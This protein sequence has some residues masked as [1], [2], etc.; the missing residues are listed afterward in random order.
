MATGDRIADDLATKASQGLAAQVGLDPEKWSVS[1][2]S[3][4]KRPAFFSRRFERITDRRDLA[5]GEDA[6][7]CQVVATR[8]WA[9][10][11][12]P[13]VSRP[14]ADEPS[15]SPP[16]GSVTMTVAA[17]YLLDDKERAPSRYKDRGETYFAILC[18]T[19]P[20]DG[21]RHKVPLHKDAAMDIQCGEDVPVELGTRGA[22]ATA[23]VNP[24]AVTLGRL[25]LG[26]ASRSA[27]GITP[28]PHRACHSKWR[29]GTIPG[30]NP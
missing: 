18:A 2:D 10:H 8:G 22:N 7:D 14:D 23:K 19:R 20:Y 4:G 12:G 16:A 3:L 27:L 15:T 11:A 30:P 1:R 26:R 29:P 25:W 13:K 17:V 28:P 6:V 9:R 5:G 21:V 24:Q